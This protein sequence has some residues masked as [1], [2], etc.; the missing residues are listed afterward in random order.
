MSAE[1]GGNICRGNSPGEDVWGE[2]PTPVK[3]IHSITVMDMVADKDYG[4]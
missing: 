3:Y 2:C 1:K 4:R